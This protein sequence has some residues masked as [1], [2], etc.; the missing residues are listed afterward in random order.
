MQRVHKTVLVPYSARQMFDLVDDVARY[1]EFLPWCGG[2]EV[3]ES[4]RDGKT[5]R[6]DIDY[7]GVRAHFTTENANVAGESIAIKLKDGPFRALHGTW[8]FR[9]LA[10]QACK[11]EFTLAYEFKTSVL[12]AVVGPVFNHIASTFIDAFVR[13][14]EAV[15]AKAK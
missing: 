11:V 3:Q 6:I 1:P 4:R 15:Y 10:P 5:A 8:K 13:R 2:A 7:H 9:K 14:A 12:E